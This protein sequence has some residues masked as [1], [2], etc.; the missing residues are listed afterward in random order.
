MGKRLIIFLLF[1]VLVFGACNQVG[2][3]SYTYGAIK[4]VMLDLEHAIASGDVEAWLDCHTG[5]DDPHKARQQF[6]QSFG[7]CSYYEIKDFS[8][9]EID[10][11]KASCEM[12]IEIEVSGKREAQT[13]LEYLEKTDEGWQIIYKGSELDNL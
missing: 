1:T 11:S 10:G 8:N 5:V 2:K 6:Q 9:I 13:K 12:K 4:Q 3:S 7:E